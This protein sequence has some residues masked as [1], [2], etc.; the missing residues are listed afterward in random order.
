MY[1]VVT[2]SPH[3]E[4]EEEEKSGLLC[5]LGGD[6]LPAVAHGCRVCWRHFAAATRRC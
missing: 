2:S 3:G 4:G 6:Y 1:N 5:E